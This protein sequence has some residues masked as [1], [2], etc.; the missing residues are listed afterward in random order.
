MLSEK[1]VQ[2]LGLCEELAKISD[3]GQILEQFAHTKQLLDSEHVPTIAVVGMG[4]TSCSLLDAASAVC[5]VPVPEILNQTFTTGPA[6]LTLTNGE[7]E[8]LYMVS[9]ESYVQIEDVNAARRSANAIEELMFTFPCERLNTNQLILCGG[10]EGHETWKL[11]LENIDAVVLR[12]N[13]T[14][15]M[16][17]VE[18]GW[19]DNELLPLFGKKHF[20]IFIDLIDR[21]N[22]EADQADLMENV[23]AALR[24]REMDTPVFTSAKEAGAWAFTELSNMDVSEQHVQKAL[25]ICLNAINKRID[26]I[27]QLGT[28]DEKVLAKAV[29]QVESQR[30]R[31]ELAGEIAAKTTVA[32]TYSQLRIDAKSGVRDFNRQAVNSICSKIDEAKPNELE[33]LEPKIQAYLRKVWEIYQQQMNEK[34]NEESQKCYSLL[35]ERMEKDAGSM[36]SELDEETQR[37]IF[38]AMNKAASGLADTQIRP[39]W[40]YQGSNTL[41]KLKT[42]T[43]NLMLLSIPLAFTSPVL[44]LALI[45]GVRQYKKNQTEKRGEEFRESLRKQVKISCDEMVEDICKE[46]DKSFDAVAEQIE[47]SILKAYNGLTDTL[48]GQLQDL[49]QQQQTLETRITALNQVKTVTIPSII[50]SL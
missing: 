16:N 21:L 38:T 37:V 15:A 48:I 44:S 18:R 5:E 40:E 17:Q 29:D 32:N 35:M 46:V 42:E 45:F 39:D 23:K 22:T 10:V 43:R 36:L 27:N 26:N 11:L 12:I 4:P 50:L 25:K 14:A 13:A 34:L 19:I 49:R 8:R 2:A 9:A 20:A 24:K 47:C 41:T 7:K 33:S 6:S 28:I 31:L 1:H 3:D 30:S